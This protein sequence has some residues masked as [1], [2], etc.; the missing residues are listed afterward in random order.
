MKVAVLWTQL[1][2][3]ISCCM[4][5]LAA[6]PGVELYVANEAPATVAPYLS[7]VFDWIERR[8]VYAQTPD[9][10]R[11]FREL[12][13]FAPD[14]IL[15]SWHVKPFQAAC[16]RYKRSAVGVACADN[17]WFGNARQ[18]VASMTSAMHL[19][20]F[21]DAAF[22]PGERQAIWARH[23]GFDESRIWR[24]TF[25]P[26]VERFGP[27]G[28]KR[29]SD[30]RSFL[31]AG[32]L[33]QE[34]GLETL[35]EAYAGYAAAITAEGGRPWDCLVAGAG[36]LERILSH[37]GFV[38]RGFVQ[39]RDLPALFA[40]ASCFL[41]PSHY[42]P[43]GVALEEAAVSGLPI[44]CTRTC[45]ASVHMVQDNWNGYLIDPRSATQLQAAMIRMTRLPAERR[46]Q[47]AEASRTLGLQF[48]P[49]RWATTVLEKGRELQERL[50]RG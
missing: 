35:A 7:S 22:V 8:Y 49:E 4:K 42:E 6:R 3:Y 44:I 40:E 15:A 34:K 14:V 32:R 12:D 28:K 48:T 24:G 31:F 37:P 39:P 47:M 36:P 11:L 27:A 46:E 17:Q 23:M 19:R 1:A 43:W 29:R 26:D 9:P 16:L 20:K 33:S 2:G 18:R 21:Y 38:K 10:E 25:A 41:L 5:A 30:A 13:A 45:G 50:G